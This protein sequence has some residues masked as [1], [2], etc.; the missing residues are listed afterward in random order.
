M[1]ANEKSVTVSFEKFTV[2]NTSLIGTVRVVMLKGKD[3]IGS[4]SV[5]DDGEGNITIA[6]IASVGGNND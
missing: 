3:G 4:I 5:S 2:K 1:S 6:N